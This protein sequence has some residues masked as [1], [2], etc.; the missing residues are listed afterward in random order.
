MPVPHITPSDRTRFESKIGPAVPPPDHCTD[1]GPCIKWM[2]GK[3]PSGYGL[4]AFGKRSQRAN[5]ILWTIL[6]GP[7]PEGMHVLHYCDVR[8]CVAIRHLWLGTH[9]DNMHD[10]AAKGRYDTMPKGDAHQARRKPDYLARGEQVKTS[11]LTEATVRAIRTDY[12]SG[13]WTQYD[14]ADTFG[15]SQAVI[16]HVVHRKSWRHVT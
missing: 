13:R 12:A 7:I 15:V 6:R 14:L 16:W 4:F 9:A 11:K 10:R 5:R 8:D 3:T 2:G 1:R